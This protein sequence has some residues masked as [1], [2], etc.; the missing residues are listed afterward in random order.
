M[1]KTQYPLLLLLFVLGLATFYSCDQP[2]NTNEIKIGAI[3][4]LTGDA[5]FMGKIGLRGLSAAEDYINDSVLKNSNKTL[6][7]VFADG[8][9]IPKNSLNALS[10]LRNIEKTDIIF[11][12]VN[13]V[14]LSILPIQEKEKF[15]FISHATHPSLS[16][17]NDLVFRHS[18][19]VIQEFSILKNYLS[20]SHSKIALCYMN[21]DYSIPLKNLLVNNKIISTDNTVVFNKGESIFI[22]EATKLKQLNCEKIIICGTGKSLSNLVI[23]LRELGFNGEIITTLGFKVTGADK[24]LHGVKSMT[25]IDFDDIVIQQKFIG[26]ANKFKQ[27]Y[28][29]DITPG[30]IIF[31]NSALLI[32]DCIQKGAISSDSIAAKIKLMHAF[33]GMGEKIIITDSNDILPK[34]KI[35]K[36][37]E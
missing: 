10:H 4:P 25:F 37:Y 2:K 11:S 28:K 30:E 20:N 1:K 17:V 27:K 6:K 29:Q 3:L 9:G 8:N 15:L 19:T 33:E 36:Q 5:A 12:I 16:G 13:A 35:S 26:V 18:P 22:H 32:A 23:K 34:L 31:F 21:D 24:L 7:I 14:D